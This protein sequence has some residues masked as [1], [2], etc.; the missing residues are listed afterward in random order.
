MTRKPDPARIHTARRA[1][2]VYRVAGEGVPL[3]VAGAWATQWE[4]ATR[5]AREDV[6][7]W[8]DAYLWIREQR[9][10]RRRPE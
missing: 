6:R 3:D 8:D 9:E 10:T 4:L 5:L 1:G 7:Y 2:T